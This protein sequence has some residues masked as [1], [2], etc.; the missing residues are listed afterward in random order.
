MAHSA[1]LILY[2]ERSDEP[3]QSDS[4]MDWS[5]IE[6]ESVCAVEED[7]HQI[8]VF[9]IHAQK[10]TDYNWKF[11]FLKIVIFFF[12][13]YSRNNNEALSIDNT[14]GCCENSEENQLCLCHSS[15]RS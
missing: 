13:Q 4:P 10:K 3:T 11:F 12:M 15:L 5:S 8:T 2:L 9:E 7:S 1:S 14:P 6:F